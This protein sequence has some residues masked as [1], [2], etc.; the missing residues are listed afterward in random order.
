[1]VKHIESNL[2]IDVVSYLHSRSI[3]CLHIPNE[4]NTGVVELKRL[5]RMGVKKGAPDLIINNGKQW[6]W[7]ELKTD[8]G[9]Q[10]IE[11]V[12]FMNVA[13]EFGIPYYIIRS[14]DDAKRVIDGW[15]NGRTSVSKTE[16]VGPIPSLSATR[17]GEKHEKNMEQLAVGNK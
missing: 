11:Q 5:T 14:V 7:W 4:R 8:K 12:C 16:D 9:K 1:M 10:S 15:F 17:I 13:K 2:Q 3:F 6:Q